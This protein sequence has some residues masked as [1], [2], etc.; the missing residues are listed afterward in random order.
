[1]GGTPHDLPAHVI[2][3]IISSIKDPNSKKAV[4]LALPYAREAHPLNPPK[5]VKMH[6]PLEKDMPKFAKIKNE[7]EKSLDTIKTE[8]NVEVVNGNLICKLNTLIKVYDYPDQQKWNH[9]DVFLTMPGDRND[10]KLMWYAPLYG[11]PGELV[12]LDESYDEYGAV[13]KQFAIG[14][15][16]N[17]FFTATWWKDVIDH[18]QL[19]P[20][21]I[22]QDIVNKLKPETKITTEFEGSSDIWTLIMGKEDI[23]IRAP[24]VYYFNYM[25]DPYEL[26]YGDVEQYYSEMSDSGSESD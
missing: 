23:D 8:K 21:Y 16:G 7:Y 18:N 22:S 26:Y 24:G 10:N 11:Q 9:G 15:P 25:E 2:E 5:S 4:R 3:K 17:L 20:V 6:K 13:P 14:L 12:Q 19:V 1:M